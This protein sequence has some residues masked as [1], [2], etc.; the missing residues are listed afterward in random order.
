MAEA[1]AGGHEAGYSADFREYTSEL[2]LETS[3]T[4]PD[5]RFVE[6]FRPSNRIVRAGLLGADVAGNLAIEIPP[7]SHEG[8]QVGHLFGGD[9]L[10]HAIRHQGQACGR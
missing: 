3:T 6:V 7:V 10:F 5:P 8:N 2:G 9:V 1:R 4:S